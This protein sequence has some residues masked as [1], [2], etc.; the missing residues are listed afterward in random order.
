MRTIRYHSAYNLRRLRVIRLAA[1]FGLLIAALVIPLIPII[2][3]AETDGSV[4]FDRDKNAKNP[5]AGES[6]Y[7]DPLSETKRWANG[8]REENEQEAALIDVIADQPTAEWFGWWTKDV[9][10]AVKNSVTNMTL[11]NMLPVLVAYHIPAMDCGAFSSNEI[12]LKQY[13]EWIAD[14]AE[15]IGNRK[16]VVILEPDALAALDCLSKEDQQTRLNLIREAVDAFN[17][18]P[19]TS[20]YIDAGHPLWMPPLVM[21]ER[22]KAAG[23]MN[24]RGFVLNTSNFIDTIDNITYGKII[25]RHLNDKAMLIDTSRNGNGPAHNFEW[26]NPIGRA[27]GEKPTTKPADPYVDAYLWIK[28]PAYSDGYCNGGPSAGTFWPQ[29]ALDLAARTKW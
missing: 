11:Q 2:T 21:V 23:V 27:L 7:V 20:V 29:Y 17:A 22:L 16:A 26:C 15:G 3:H 13:R 12:R 6:L 18:L 24:A 19:K 5:F 28:H 9:H 14:F 25:S 4:H 10:T 1:F 8:R